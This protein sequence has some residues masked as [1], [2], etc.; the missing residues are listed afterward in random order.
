MLAGRGGRIVNTGFR[1]GGPELEAWREELGG[2]GEF[3]LDQPD[4]EFVRGRTRELSRVARRR[5]TGYEWEVHVIITQILGRLLKA[6][7]VFTLPDVEVPKPLTRAI[8]LVMA[9]P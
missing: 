1:F 8:S 4:F 7:R 5:P 9:D 2:E 3:A 6:R